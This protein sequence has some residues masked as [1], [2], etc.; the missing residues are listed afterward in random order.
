MCSGIGFS[1]PT[2]ELALANLIFKFERK[3]P[4]DHVGQLDMIEAPGLTTKRMKNL[5]LVPKPY[6]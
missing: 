6:L 4:D 2:V 3:L 5:Y 1:I